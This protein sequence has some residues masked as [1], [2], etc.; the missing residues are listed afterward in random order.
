MTDVVISPFLSGWCAASISAASVTSCVLPTVLRVEHVASVTLNNFLHSSL[1]DDA[2]CERDAPSL[3]RS[4]ALLAS[5][6]KGLIVRRVHEKP[7]EKTAAD[8]SKLFRSRFSAFDLVT[9]CIERESGLMLAA[10]RL[11]RDIRLR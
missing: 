10:L 7:K 6:I 11:N 3:R 1:V 2:G 4:G 8:G 9:S 5:L